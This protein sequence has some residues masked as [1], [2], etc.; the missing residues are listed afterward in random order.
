MIQ[1]KSYYNLIW[2]VYSVDFF[3]MHELAMS[4][5]KVRVV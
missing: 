4:C 2:G 3:S 5:N 1:I